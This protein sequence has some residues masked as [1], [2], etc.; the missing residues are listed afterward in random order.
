MHL[1]SIRIDIVFDSLGESSLISLYDA[2]ISISRAPG[3]SFHWEI[4]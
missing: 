2:G 1:W 4:V 3:A